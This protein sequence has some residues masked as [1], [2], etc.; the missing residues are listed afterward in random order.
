MPHNN[1]KWNIWVV[2][3]CFHSVYFLLLFVLAT[4]RVEPGGAEEKSRGGE[5]TE[6]TGGESATPSIMNHPFS[7]PSSSNSTTI[8]IIINIII[9]RRWD[10]TGK[11]PKI[12]Y[13]LLLLAP[14][15]SPLT[16][17]PSP[18]SS[19][20]SPSAPGP[21]P[22]WGFARRRLHVRGE[23]L[24]RGTYIWSDWH[25]E[26]SGE[27]LFKDFRVYRTRTEQRF[28]WGPKNVHVPQRVWVVKEII[29]RKMDSFE[30]LF[31]FRSAWSSFF[32]YLPSSSTSSTPPGDKHAFTKLTFYWASWRKKSIHL[33]FRQI[34]LVQRMKAKREE[35]S[36]K[37]D[38]SSSRID[39]LH[40]C[41]C[42]RKK[43]KKVQPQWILLKMVLNLVS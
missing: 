18:P 12:H 19:Q 14:L 24:G 11:A 40:F 28:W 7:S 9:Q 31:D 22:R 17:S 39:S 33:R 3:L 16:P 20:T 4:E 35:S 5:E 34:K 37:R 23:R 1:I 2:L 26:D 25:R 27:Y 38:W 6:I 32:P 30:Y 36:R 21:E 10:C 43:R 29:L 42:R 41:G 13:I 15:P 8:T